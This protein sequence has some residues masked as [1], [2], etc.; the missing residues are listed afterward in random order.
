MKKHL[1]LIAVIPFII[2]G[3]GGSSSYNNGV[4]ADNVGVY[5]DSAIEGVEYKCGQYSGTTNAQGEFKYDFNKSCKFTF[6]GNTLEEVPDEYLNIKNAHIVV[7][8]DTALFLAKLDSKG[9]LDDGININREIASK[10]FHKG[11]SKDEA[12]EALKKY[13]KKV[14][15]ELNFPLISTDDVK[16][17]QEKQ[18]KKIL[19]SKTF[20][21]YIKFC[22]GCQYDKLKDTN[23]T[24]HIFVI[25]YELDKDLT[26]LTRTFYD[27]DNNKPDT[28][29][30]SITL[31]G[32]TL[33]VDP[34]GAL[35]VSLYSDEYLIIHRED[36]GE[37]SYMKLFT[38]KDGL[39][40]E[41]EDKN[42]T[43]IPNF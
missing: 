3:C 4:K 43:K 32:S 26:T 35:S 34:I 31:D 8:G 33:N 22:P 36:D 21:S 9:N 14:K 17:H 2:A 11:M 23:S 12:F 5:E 39:L 18:L 10:Y 13:Q 15:K 19:A 38:T 16:K 29:V 24:E 30:G 27:E 40:K 41:L 37:E 1:L 28:Y 7:N 6:F 42:I 25:K 20:Y